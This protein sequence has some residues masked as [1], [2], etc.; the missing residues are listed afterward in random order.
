MRVAVVHTHTH[1]RTHARTHT[2]NAD[3][4]T[5]PAY[6]S[7]EHFKQQDTKT[8]PISRESV[9]LSPQYFGGHVVRST[10]SV[11]YVRRK[12]C[13]PYRTAL[14][15]SYRQ[16]VT[17]GSQEKSWESGTHLSTFSTENHITAQEASDK[18]LSE[19]H[20]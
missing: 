19:Q 3:R 15:G 7:C 9:G 12:A 14:G 8:P 4:L 1:A 10:C 11:C 17:S 20:T 2:H 13:N 18:V 6:L 16:Q 5:A